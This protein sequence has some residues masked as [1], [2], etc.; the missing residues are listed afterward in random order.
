MNL[1]VLSVSGINT[2]IKSVIEGDEKLADIF[3]EGEISNFKN[4]YA[5]GHL[6][7]SLK[8]DKSV[9]RCVMFSSY[10][11]RLRF[12]P[13]NS[14]HI[15][16]RG[17]IAVYER[18][19]Q[20]QLYPEDMHPVG[21]GALALRYEQLKKQLAA[22]GLFD[23]SSKRKIPEKPKTIAVVTSETGAAVHDILNVLARRAPF[24]RVVICPVLVQGEKAAESMVNT[25]EKLYG[26]SGIDTIIIGRGGGSFEELF[27][28][29][30]EGLVRKLY[31]SPIPVISA[32]GHET[33]VTLCDLVAD[34]RAPTPSAAA[35]LAVRDI[36]ADSA[37]VGEATIRM[38]QAVKRT[39]YTAAERLDKALLSNVL[40]PQADITAPF[41]ARYNAVRDKLKKSARIDFNQNETRF[42]NSA[43]K[44][45]ALNPMSVL[46][47]GYTVCTSDDKVVTSVCGLKTDDVVNLKFHDGDVDCRVI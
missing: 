32:V 40:S 25:L 36:L 21:V 27:C 28:F 41:T 29:N 12:K 44:L 13:E 2:Y 30:D 10:A 11:A 35:E 19:G 15:I 37:F 47:R 45:E 39:L 16:C 38:S 4:H 8:D 9:I 7:F 34:L 22:D 17:K 5:S 20:Y 6:Y 18:D 24:T 3:V 33:D 43:V 26:L 31:E 23:I 46:L 1:P 14:M 42:M